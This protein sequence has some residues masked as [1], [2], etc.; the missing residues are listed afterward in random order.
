MLTNL[1]EVYY[2]MLH[3]NYLSLMVSDKKIFHVPHILV[4]LCKI[5]DIHGESFSAPG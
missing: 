3:I 5:R 2:V 1:V 4:G